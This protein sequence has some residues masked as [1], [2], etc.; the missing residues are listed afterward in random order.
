MMCTPT[1]PTRHPDD[2]DL[3]ELSAEGRRVGPSSH[4]LCAGD[5]PSLG[6]RSTHGP[7]RSSVIEFAI[8]SRKERKERKER[9]REA[10]RTKRAAQRRYEENFRAITTVAQRQMMD[11]ISTTEVGWSHI[12]ERYSDGSLLV[13]L[14]YDRGEMKSMVWFEP[15]RHPPKPPDFDYVLRPDGST[16]WQAP[17]QPV[18]RSAFP[19]EP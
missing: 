9:E 3:R 12:K 13:R 10:E 8:I 5:G 4:S 1:W 14:Y 15:Q 19:W 16:N 17:S 6:R 11:Y 18:R 2:G 7:A